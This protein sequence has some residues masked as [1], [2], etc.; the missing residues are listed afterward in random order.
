M[1]RR[2]RRP[3][4]LAVPPRRRAVDACQR[5]LSANTNCCLVSAHSRMRVMFYSPVCVRVDVHI[6]WVISAFISALNGP[7]PRSI[8]QSRGRSD[9][10]IG[11]CSKRG[12]ARYG[13]WRGTCAVEFDYVEV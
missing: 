11:L 2:A 3:T 12:A 8:P 7:W 9:V 6:Q 10:A 5:W 4:V 13:W 1:R